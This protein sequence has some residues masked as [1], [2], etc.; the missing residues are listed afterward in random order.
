MALNDIGL[1][2]RELGA[3]DAALDYYQRSLALYERLGPGSRGHAIALLDMGVNS[4]KRGDT[5]A[6][7][8]YDS[9]ALAIL[10]D[11]APDSMEVARVLVNLGVLYNS[12]GADTRAVELWERAL[13]ICERIAP[14]SQPM[15]AALYHRGW[16]LF[17][18]GDYDAALHDF[19][20][21][22]AIL[23]HLAPGS[24]QVAA[25]LHAIGVARGYR[26][27]LAGGL[28]YIQRA[29]PMF[30]AM[31]PMSASMAIA[32]HDAGCLHQGLGDLDAA[33]QCFQRSLEIEERL[34]VE[35]AGRQAHNL[36]NLGSVYRERGDEEGA[37]AY[38][39]RAVEVWESARH[40]VVM[41]DEAR[42]SFLE[43]H[44]NL[45][46]LLIAGLYALGE[47]AEAADVSERMRARSLLDLIVERPLAGSAANPELAAR[48]AELDARR[49]R[50]HAQLS[51][52]AG[53]APDADRAAELSAELQRV[54]LAQEVLA[55]EV[56][57]ADPRYATLQYPEPMTVAQLREAL[58]PG[59][60]VLSYVVGNEFTGL[61]VFG[62]GLETTAHEIDLAPDALGEGVHGLLSLVAQ[63]QQWTPQVRATRVQTTVSET[64]GGPEALARAARELGEVL[65]GPARAQIDGA[66]RLLI[67]PDGPL[68]ALPFQA[69]LVDDDTWLCDLKP[70]HFASSATVFAEQRRLRQMGGAG[71]GL[72][73]LGN[74]AYGAVALQ[75]ARGLSAPI[76][77]SAFRAA[78]RS[79]GQL[80]FAALP[81]SGAEVR[82]IGDLF[83]PSAE[84]LEGAAASEM[85]LRASSPG[86][87][88]LHLACHGLVDTAS[89]MDSA[90]V[91]S[92]AD[93]SQP[94]S[95]G[96]LKTWEIFDLDLAGC[97]LVTLSA[98]ESARGEV[99]SGE[100]VI[101]LTRAF[102]YAGAAS[103]LCTQWQVADRSTAA[104]MVRFYAHYT[105]GASKDQALR[106]AM[107]E[108]RTGRQVDGSALQLPPGIGPWR[109]QW[110]QPYYWAP[111]ILVG[112]WRTAEESPAQP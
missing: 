56:R 41:G 28:S 68:W 112:E 72:I 3:I 95:D 96:F 26:G 45:Y 15:A 19:E 79:R 102:I 48:Q 76:R 46:H 32:T 35:S 7:L 77:A 12:Q 70:V 104:L 105:D 47:V 89:P 69:L 61:F 18:T 73:A 6:A 57:R 97:D 65:L 17:D 94:A 86:R 90:L 74:P 55:N 51:G 75:D 110:A 59:T 53:D 25:T 5:A 14:D 58:D 9:R 30:E 62:P 107:R 20:R 88:V 2:Q 31:R 42:S 23:E 16:H 67:L 99:R 64:G 63:G 39:R 27:D 101:G 100:G 85:S 103:V 4:D 87:R 22:L 54:E 21:S 92:S 33:L 37:V 29:L 13:G 60:V 106:M 111:F 1:V 38:F 34:P 43:S 66:R 10:E 44:L 108:L 50:L 80:G 52:L 84:V 109:A 24:V 82:T 83:S 11:M 78:S 71:P 8:E 49:D 91:L 81:C 36:I 40:Y 98:C 93:W